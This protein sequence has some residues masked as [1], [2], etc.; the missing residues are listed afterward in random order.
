MPIILSMPDT[1]T[2]S[3]TVFK[4]LISVK[5]SLDFDAVLTKFPT[6]LGISF[7]FLTRS[8]TVLAKLIGKGPLGKIKDPIMRDGRM[9]ADPELAEGGIVDKPTRAIIG[10]KGPEAIIPLNQ[11]G[12]IGGFAGTLIGATESA[13]SRMGAAGEIARTLIGGDLKSAAEMFGASSS[14]GVGGDSLGKSVNKGQIKSLMG[15]DQGED[16]SEYIGD[17]TVSILPILYQ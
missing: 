4:Y 17:G 6:A 1:F 13:L 9:L 3:F 5:A 16:I 2:V 11:I 10:E 7:G 14:G 15:L 8:I 12:N